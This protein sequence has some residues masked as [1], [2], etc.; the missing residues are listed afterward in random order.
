MFR[1][2]V[3]YSLANQQTLEAIISYTYEYIVH[4]IPNTRNSST[5]MERL[6]NVNRF[7]T[8]HKITTAATKLAFASNP[9]ASAI[10][11]DTERIEPGLW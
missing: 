9:P 7:P 10:P 11:T 8:L 4:L 2:V 1:W 3:M 5:Y 6:Q